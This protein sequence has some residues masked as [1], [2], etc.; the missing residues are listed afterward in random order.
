MKQSWDVQTGGKWGH[1]PS[2]GGNF[3]ECTVGA[4][5]PGISFERSGGQREAVGM[6]DNCLSFPA[7]Q[8]QLKG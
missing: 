5:Q 6:N 2:V 8:H 1:L 3:L 4:P 7:V